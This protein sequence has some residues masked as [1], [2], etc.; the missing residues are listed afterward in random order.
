ME[1]Q[2]SKAFCVETKGFCIFCLNPTSKLGKNE[3]D[4][5]DDPK[6]ISQ[7]VSLKRL[8]R[9]LNVDFRKVFNL[10]IPLQQYMNFEKSDVI[11]P[12][13]LECAKVTRK[14]SKLHHELE[15][16][17]MHLHSCVQS[18]C[19]RMMKVESRHEILE[20][21]RK[22]WTMSN[23]IDAIQAGIVDNMRKETKD[24]CNLFKVSNY[25][26]LYR[27]KLIFT[28]RNYGFVS[29][30]GFI[31]TSK[32]LP[33]VKLEKMKRSFKCPK[34][35]ME[36]E[37]EIISRKRVCGDQSN[38]IDPNIS[39]V[40]KQSPIHMPAHVPTSIP[41]TTKNSDVIEKHPSQSQKSQQST[42]STSN[43]TTE[44]NHVNTFNSWGEM[45]PPPVSSVQHQQS[46]Y[47]SHIASCAK[48]TGN[49]HVILKKLKTLFVLIL[50]LQ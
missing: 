9:Y 30:L 1:T 21:Y 13:C 11:V 50:T 32:G 35:A 33:R 27:Y 12:L 25:F 16:V 24:K 20:K 34:T 4:S 3:D 19:E 5:D 31:K 47:L 17:K 10:N 44:T 8:S 22:R 28:M 36:K 18:I 23:H 15:L 26:N 40:K 38:S 42:L 2:K 29:I 49:L 39:P 7:N 45:R 37:P 6:I 48:T 41:V 43:L 46:S 14:F